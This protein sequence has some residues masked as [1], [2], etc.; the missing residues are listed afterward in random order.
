V[1]AYLDQPA[2]LTH[3]RNPQDLMAEQMRFWQTAAGQYQDSGR[4]MM[5][6]WAQ[7][8]PELPFAQP[9]SGKPVNRDYM[10]VDRDDERAGSQSYANG[11][12]A[13]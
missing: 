6:L 12:Q 8:V 2:R 7:A 11:R 1:Q 13:A 5:T 3:C 4:K 10:S 9:G